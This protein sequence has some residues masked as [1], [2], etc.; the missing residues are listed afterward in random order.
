MK[1]ESQNILEPTKSDTQDTEQ[2]PPTG[3]IATRNLDGRGK[4]RRSLEQ[5]ATLDPKEQ[6]HAL[7]DTWKQVAMGVAL[8]AKSFATTCS[9]KDFGR[10]YQL[11]MSGAVS[12]DK[13]FPPKE[14]TQS[15]RLVVNLFGSLGQRAAA[16]AIPKVPTIIN[17]VETK[18]VPVVL[19]HTTKP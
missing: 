15:P 12:L 3:D 1:P 8:R 7:R 14:Q 13:A 2:E 19:N 9:P 17:P 18:E 16:I 5:F 6:H 4:H 11:V 10:L